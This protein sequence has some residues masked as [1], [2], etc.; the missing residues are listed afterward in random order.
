MKKSALLLSLVLI[1]TGT[2]KAQE[3]PTWQTPMH[4]VKLMANGSEEAIMKVD[5][6]LR[7]ADL[8]FEERTFRLLFNYDPGHIKH[9]RIIDQDSK[10]QVVR[11]RG[12]YF[13]GNARFEFIDGD[14]FRLKMKR[15]ST[16]YE[17][18]GPYGPLFAVENHGIKPVKT[19]NEKDF[20]AQAFFVFAR[21]KS[22]QRPP[23]EVIYISSSTNAFNKNR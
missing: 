23:T 21:I 12:S 10:L 7:F 13:W 9:A 14:I 20:L 16:G 19:L 17:V 1:L 6:S 18:L 4:E 5:P 3:N 22:T 15:N 8:S 11:G 2:A